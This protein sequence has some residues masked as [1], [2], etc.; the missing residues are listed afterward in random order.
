[1]TATEA[2]VAAAMEALAKA[3]LTLDEDDDAFEW[4]QCDE[5]PNRPG[6]CACSGKPWTKDA[7][8]RPVADA[9]VAAGPDPAKVAADAGAK[10]L[11]DAAWDLD[12]P[13]TEPGTRE[14]RIGSA[15]APDWLR[16]RANQIEA[17]Q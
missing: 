3:L 9:V 15:G 12:I 17:G 6:P 14:D 16:H 13:N 1:M 10:A 5:C 7:I 8:A 4:C 11:R 2:Q